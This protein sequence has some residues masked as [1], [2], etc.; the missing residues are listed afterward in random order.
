VSQ[1][2]WEYPQPLLRSAPRKLPI[3]PK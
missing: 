1:K 3:S 2:V